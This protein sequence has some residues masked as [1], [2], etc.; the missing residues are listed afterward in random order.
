LL[1]SHHLCHEILS[2][3]GTGAHTAT[4]NPTSAAPAA[5]TAATTVLLVSLVVLDAIL[6]FFLHDFSGRGTTAPDADA[7]AVLITGESNVAQ[8]HTLYVTVFREVHPQTGRAHAL[9]HKLTHAGSPAEARVGHHGGFKPPRARAVAH[10][11]AFFRLLIDGQ[12]GRISHQKVRFAL[13]RSQIA[14]PSTIA[15]F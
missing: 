11:P 4:N 9:V 10:A 7:A 6:A 5:T 8:P 14:L 3:T 15:F 12:H 13:Q 2:A 1:L